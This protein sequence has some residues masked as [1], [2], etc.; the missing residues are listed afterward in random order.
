MCVPAVPLSLTVEFAIV[1]A[2]VSIPVPLIS[3]PLSIFSSSPSIFTAA[4]AVVSAFLVVRLPTLL[5]TLF[6]ST[7]RINL[8]PL[9]FA[10][11][12]VTYVRHGA[13]IP[14]PSQQNRAAFCLRAF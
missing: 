10:A 14:L 3:S 7:A 13:V 6:V 8:Q 11:R 5:P 1:S 12:P 9:C 4:V 2:P